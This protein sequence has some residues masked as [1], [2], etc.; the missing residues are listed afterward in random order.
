MD[1]EL[2]IKGIKARQIL[3]SRGNP[4]VEADVF[5]SSGHVG[6]AIVPSGASTGSGEALELRDGDPAY[7]NGKG[8]LKAVWNVNSKI[9]DVLVGNSAKQE[10]VDRLM[11]ELDGT[12]N[13]SSLGANAILAVSMATAKA[14]AKAN[15]LHFY[16]YIAKIAGTE[17][18]MSLPMPMMN[19]M[20]GGAHAGWST[21]FQEYMI[22]PNGA[23]NINDAIRM[24]AEVFHALA[25][26]LKDRDYPTTVGD[27]GGYAPRVH[28]GN[29]E[30]L[31]CIRQAILEAGYRPGDDISMAMDVASSEFYDTDHYV[32]KTNGDWK[33]SE[34]LIN[35][36]TWI[37]ENYPVV[38]IEDGL[39]ESDWDG[40]K[41]LTERL[42]GRMQLVGDDLFVT[43]TKLLKKGIDEKAGN[44]IL[45]KPNQI[46]TLTETIEAVLMAKKAG[47]KTV[48]SHRSGE[49]EDN[50]ISHLAV[51]L[52]TGQIKTGSLSRSERIAKYNELMRI[53]EGNSTLG[54]TNP[55]KER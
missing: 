11:I 27:E 48:M 33:S 17:D 42:G 6:R 44:A 21:D 51:G 5:L 40:W 49:S 45:I 26:V 15:N 22:I 13:K 28:D 7:Y 24:G 55:F 34:D 31:E 52:G 36:Y 50:S 38:S 19:V 35:W 10:N 23:E 20:N 41:V 53:F 25:K 16:E 32:L 30:P 37:L 54:L 1:K 3:D 12:E 43:N 14:V 2:T 9:R 46:G 29:N 4:T 8:V 39:S 47:F 18:E